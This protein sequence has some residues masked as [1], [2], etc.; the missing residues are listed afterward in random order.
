MLGDDEMQRKA[1]RYMA[2]FIICLVLLLS[3]CGGTPGIT[4]EPTEAIETP[5]A[6]LPPTLEVSTVPTA[7]LAPSP[8][9]SLTVEP[10][11]T[12]SPLPSLTA[13]PSPTLPLPDEV[14]VREATTSILHY[15]YELYL[16][17]AFDAQ[18]GVPYLWLDRTAYDEHTGAATPRTFRAVI[19]EN[20]YLQLTILPELGGRI[21]G[22]I[23]KPTGQNILYRNQVLKPTAWGPLTLEENWWLAAGGIEWAF[24]VNEH[25]YEWGLPWSYSIERSATETT[26][27]LWDSAENRP[28][29][30][31]E[32]ALAPG[33]AYFAIRPRIENPTTS[34][35]NYQYWTDAMLTLGS[36][37]MSRRT[38]FVYPTEQVIIHSAGPDS[39]LPGESSRIGWPLY[40]GRDMAWYYNWADWLGFF[41][42]QPKE[43]F[44]GAY[45][46]DTGL[47]VARIFPRQEVPGVKLFAWGQESP[48]TVE[49][50]DDGSQ[51]FEIWGGPNRTFW[52]E[53]DNSL[54]SGE[55]KAWTEYWYPFYQIGGLDF[56]NREAA[57][58]LEA[59]P[60]SLHLGLAT[61]SYQK[62]TIVL[63]LGEDELHRQEVAVSP[64][65][66]YVREV[67]LPAGAPARA[68]VSLRFLGADDTVI[69]RFGENTVFP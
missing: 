17:E 62:G 4:P 47:G 23:F 45:N 33:K 39:G 63:L 1:R 49:Y 21:Y 52:P 48:Y 9:P 3:A 32:I 12:P 55:S 65:S 2:L 53:D 7:T 40:E 36:P 41:I 25:G 69:V 67:P 43:D 18:H 31:V 59:Q 60:G 24:P 46:H 11:P 29:M 54:G 30:S 38:E 35:I 27:T 8:S 57:L 68:H 10:S 56:A 28:R 51:Y 61:T 26:I 14:L 34:D 15:P 66:P 37:S 16:H 44:V 20:R 64:D 5:T 50:T 58:S 22:C 42:P 6:A 19:L 13:E